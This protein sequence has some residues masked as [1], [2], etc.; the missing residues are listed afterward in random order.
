MLLSGW[1][2]ELVLERT[3]DKQ[4]EANYRRSILRYSQWLGHAA[5]VSDLVEIQINRWLK[6]MEDSKASR[7]VLGHK[8]AITV[9]WNWL[10]DRNLVK[11]YEMQRLRKIKVEQVIPVAWTLPN[12]KLLLDAAE[13]LPGSTSCGVQASDLMRALIL[14]AYES[15]CRPSDLRALR[16]DAI[17]GSRVTIVQHKTSVMHSFGLSRHALDALGRVIRPN[18]TYVFPASRNTIRRWELRLFSAAEK[19][20]FSRRKGQALGTLRKTHG[21]EVCRSQG[22]EVAARSLGHISGTAIAKNHYVAPDALPQPSAPPA[23][24]NELSNPKR[25]KPLPSDRHGRTGG[26]RRSV[27]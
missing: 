5:T 19:L 10:A 14:V 7:T 27:G 6:S 4:T 16:V 2:D 24:I 13:T 22:L 11:R 12:V 21:T 20:G 18:A 23:L 17:Q 8:R 9:L 25:T 3:I 1:M 26:V 15:G